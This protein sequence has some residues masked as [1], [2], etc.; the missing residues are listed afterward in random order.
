MKYTETVIERTG[1]GVDED[2]ATSTQM[3]VSMPPKWM[4]PSK[5]IRAG[6]G[7]I[8]FV[9]TMNDY[10]GMRVSGVVVGR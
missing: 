4:L 2:Y 9:L 8:E 3:T 10:P 7:R 1:T 6:T 5:I